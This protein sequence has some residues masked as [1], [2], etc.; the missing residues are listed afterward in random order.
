VPDGLSPAARK[1]F[2][3]VVMTEKATHFT[4]SDLSLLVQYCEACALAERAIAHL[5]RNTAPRWLTT[6][7]TAVKVMK[8]LAMRLRLSPQ[9]RQPNNPS[10]KAPERLSF[11]DR[12]V[13]EGEADGPKRPD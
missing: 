6:W 10:R 11:Y 7:Q 9:S 1:E 13:L 4:A 12:M 3:R 8:D 5:Q 2:L